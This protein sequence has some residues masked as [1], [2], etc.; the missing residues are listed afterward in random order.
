MKE[1]KCELEA[2]ADSIGLLL[3]DCQCE[4]LENGEELWWRVRLCEGKYLVVRALI[5]REEEK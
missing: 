3:A 5:V 1:R 4:K 2:A